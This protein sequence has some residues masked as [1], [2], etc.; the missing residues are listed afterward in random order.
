MFR[1]FESLIDPF[2]DHDESM[3]PASLLGFYWR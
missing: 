3:P 1:L 2:R